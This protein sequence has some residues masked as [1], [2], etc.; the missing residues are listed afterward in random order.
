MNAS[1]HPDLVGRYRECAVLDELLTAPRAGEPRVRVFRGEAGMGKSV[2]L[3]YAAA[4]ASHMTV[5]RAQGVE[6]DMGL[7]YASLH[8]L[9]A[10]FLAQVDELPAPQ[11]DALRVAFGMAAGDPPDRFLVGLAVLTLLTRA[12]ENRTV[13]VLVDDAQWLDQVSLQ[14]LGFVARRART[15]GLIDLRGFLRFR[16]PLV[17]SAVYHQADIEERRAVHRALAAATDPDLDPDRRAW[18]AAQAA[19]GPDEEV[20]AGLERAADRARQRGGIAAEAVLLERAA[21]LTPDPW[22]RGRRAVA[23]AETHFSAA[24]PDRATEQATLAELCP[25]SALDRARLARLRA[26]ILFARSRSDEAAPLLLEAAAQFT[27]ADS[28]LAP[29]TYLGA[30]NAA[31]FAGTVHGPTG[32]RAAAAAARASGA[33]PSGSEAADLLLDGVAAILTEEYA[34][35]LTALRRALDLLAQEE[36]PTR[37]ATMRWL[38]LVPVAL[39]AFIHYAWDL[40]AWDTLATRAVRLAHD[41]GALGELPPALIYAGGVHIHYGDFAEAARM[42][43]EADAI[44]AATGHAPHTY[45]SLVL[46]AWRGDADAAAH[47]VVGAR[48]GALQ[49]GEV[50]LLGAMGY[51]QGVLF[52]GLARYDEALAAA[53]SAIEHDG[54]NFRGLSLVEHIEAPPG[55]AD[56]TRPAPRSRGCSTSPV[57]P[58]PGGPPAP[59]PAAVP[60]SPRTTKLMPSTASPS[61]SSAVAASPW[62]WP[63]R[64]CCTASGSA[65]TAGPRRR[66][67][68]CAQPST[69]STACGPRRSPSGPAAN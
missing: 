66:G 57:P 24:D 14:T 7:P 16:H 1:K 45:A 5:T 47:I 51:I 55:A 28:P 8:Q 22:S 10:P 29:L 50:S 33:P 27:A 2:L 62:R 46:A 61:R 58:T 68:T 25:L 4:R 32:A 49:R 21:Q 59:E 31:I 69:C 52:N 67:N 44:A 23:A 37:E 40:H 38:L 39:E 11:R 19:S 53:R 26:R 56:S 41:I 18:H 34:S 60:S 48:A 20:A 30:I 9:C 12:S 42:I 3:E 64:I 13:L 17:R 15:A 43:D 54:F 63:A 6:A 36:L 35:G 65:A